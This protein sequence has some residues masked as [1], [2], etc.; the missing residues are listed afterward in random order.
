MV[1][2]R[3]G[4]AVDGD[5]EV[6]FLVTDGFRAYIFSRLTIITKIAR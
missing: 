6:F 5:V 1:Q 3:R 4:L 2:T